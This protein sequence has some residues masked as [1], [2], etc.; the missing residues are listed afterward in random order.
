MLLAVFFIAITLNK[1]YIFYRYLSSHEIQSTQTHS[2]DS[3]FSN[4]CDRMLTLVSRIR[5]PTPV[6]NQPAKR[7]CC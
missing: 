6:F 2:S 1:I 3:L 4:I 5:C 7:L